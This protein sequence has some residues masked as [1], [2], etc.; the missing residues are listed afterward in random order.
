[1]EH[2]RDGELTDVEL[3]AGEAELR[4]LLGRWGEPQMVSP[5]ADLSAR[6]VRRLSNPP[7]KRWRWYRLWP[8][9]PFLLV[10]LGMWGLLIDSD[11][12]AALF[13]DPETGVGRLVLTLILIAKPLW[14]LWLAAAWWLLPGL[15]LLLSVGWMW[16]RLIADAPLAEV[17]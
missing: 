12:P 4:M 3:E 6:I 16:W 2:G 10:L 17:S 14:Y 9:V 11:A 1:M 7:P 8:V 15:L 13:G 5:P